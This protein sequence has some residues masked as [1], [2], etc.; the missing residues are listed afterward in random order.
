MKDLR[1]VDIIIG[2]TVVFARSTG[3]FGSNRLTEATVLKICKKTVTLGYQMRDGEHREGNYNP[4]SIMVVVDLPAPNINTDLRAG[5]KFDVFDWYEDKIVTVEAMNST[6]IRHDESYVNYLYN[7]R[8]RTA[9]WETDD[10]RW[11]TDD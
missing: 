8:K 5:D 7:G 9:T 1:G 3:S 11:E 2:Q 6:Y 4:K 10:F